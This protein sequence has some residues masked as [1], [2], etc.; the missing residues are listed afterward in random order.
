MNYT[1]VLMSASA[2]ALGFLGLVGSFLPDEVLSHLGVTG[3]PGPPALLIQITGALYLGFAGLNWMA[4]DNLIG[5][6]Y[7]RPV[8]TGN[9]LHFLTAG[10]AMI[11]FVARS[12]EFTVVWVLSLM[13]AVFAFS[14]GVVLF[15]HPIRST[16]PPPTPG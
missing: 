5:G 7:S 10:L 13:Y 3:Q 15:R 6:I 12:P 4:R 11:R 1:R 14:F 8:A 16:A 2:V 9:L